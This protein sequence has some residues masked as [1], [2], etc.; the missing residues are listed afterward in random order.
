MAATPL[1]IPLANPELN[2]TE[3]AQLMARRYHAEFIDLRDFKIQHELGTRSA[4]CS[5]SGCWGASRHARR[6]PTC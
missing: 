5:V 4:D 3:R 6:L 2:E 1:A